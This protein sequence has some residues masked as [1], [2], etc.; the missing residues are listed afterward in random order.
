MRSSPPPSA[1]RISVARR[2]AS[3]W[4]AHNAPARLPPGFL[5]HHIAGMGLSSTFDRFR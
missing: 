5:S 2:I 1:V 4:V 3:S